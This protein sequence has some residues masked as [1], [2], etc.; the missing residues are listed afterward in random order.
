MIEFVPQ[1]QSV[2]SRTKRRPYRRH[3]DEFKRAAVARTQVDGAT[4]ALIARELKINTSMN[5]APLA[6]PISISERAPEEQAQK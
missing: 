6:T 1:I 4:V 5:G 2:T 3:S